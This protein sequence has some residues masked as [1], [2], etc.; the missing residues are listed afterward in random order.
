MGKSLRP[1]DLKLHW[2]L[3]EYECV[4]QLTLRLMKKVALV[5]VNGQMIYLGGEPQEGF[6][7]IQTDHGSVASPHGQASGLLRQSSTSQE[8]PKTIAGEPATRISSG[9]I[10]L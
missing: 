1:E 8:V 7:H 10:G 9:F 6:V 5:F 2:N 3:I 4:L